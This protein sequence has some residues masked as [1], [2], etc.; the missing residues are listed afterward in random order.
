MSTSFRTQSK[1]PVEPVGAPRESAQ[2]KWLSGIVPP[3][4]TPL[5]AHDELD[6]EGLERLIEHLI[7]GGVHGLF[8]LGSTG[9]GPSLSHSVRRQLIDLTMRFVA[10]RTP[11]LV[12]ITDTSY[13]EAIELARFAAEA[14]AR[15]VVA[16]V[17]F[18]FRPSQDELLEYTRQL[19]ES[20]PIPLVLYNIPQVTKTW[21]EVETVRRA[22]EIENV[23]G[24]KDSSGD[25][26]YF[27]QLQS[28]V[29]DRPDISLLIG[30]ECLLM[31]SVLAG[32]QGGVCGGANLFPA[33]YVDLYETS[34]L[35][36]TRLAQAAHHDVE[37]INRT[38][39]AIADGDAAAIK[40]I[41]G[42]LSI[43]G[44][45]KGVLASPLLSLDADQADDLS[46]RFA[47]LSKLSSSGIRAVFKLSS[48]N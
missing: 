5:S 13:F 35:G 25:V 32:A 6:V 48:S 30:Q 21:F 40:A 31:E 20:V 16:S 47:G 3:M 11:V 23:I 42:A 29:I 12:G 26:P 45:C 7:E 19:A 36:D 15:A 2:A 46:R 34:L 37:E 44:L 10:G 14:G 39:F 22:F 38:L 1:R 33:L 28:L 8:I 17:P 41:K 4:I 9:E 24:L 43:L 27:K 18:Y